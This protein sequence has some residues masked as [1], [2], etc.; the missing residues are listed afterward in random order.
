MINSPFVHFQTREQFDKL[1]NDISDRSIVFIKDTQEIYQSGS[2]YGSLEI[3][4][5]EIS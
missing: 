4:E 2:T 3:L 5:S 1:K